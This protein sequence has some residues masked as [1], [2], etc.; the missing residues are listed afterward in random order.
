MKYLCLSLEG[1]CNI[2]LNVKNKDQD[3]LKNIR[4]TVK[5]KIQL[6]KEVKSPPSGIA[7]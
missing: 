5:T 3:T 6:M 7:S 1:K 2:Y 4:N